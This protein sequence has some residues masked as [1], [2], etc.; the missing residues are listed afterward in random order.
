MGLDVDESH[1]YT[2]ALATAKFLSTQS[3]GCSAYV[4]GAPG[5]LNALYESGITINDVDPDYVVIGET[6]NYNYDSILH[7]VKLIEKAPA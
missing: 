3:P 2:S 5:L 1:F 4:I 7:A 6:R